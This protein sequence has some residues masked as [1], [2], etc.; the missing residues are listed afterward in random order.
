MP[1]E[2]ERRLETKHRRTGVPYH[3]KEVAAMQAEADRVGLP[4][5]AVSSVPLA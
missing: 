2:R 5:L 4:R 3:A 1:G